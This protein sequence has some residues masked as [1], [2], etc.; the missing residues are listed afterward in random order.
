MQTQI[1]R[2]SYNTLRPI[3][4]TKYARDKNAMCYINCLICYLKE[5]SQSLSAQWVTTKKHVITEY[6]ETTFL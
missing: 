4:Y 3:M 5:N 6:S 2:N 1:V